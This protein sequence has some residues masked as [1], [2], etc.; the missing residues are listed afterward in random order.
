MAQKDIMP[1]NE[2]TVETDM[3]SV[4]LMRNGVHTWA[5]PLCP[6]P[7]HYRI[8]CQQKGGASHDY[9]QS[10]YISAQK[11]YQNTSP[12]NNHDNGRKNNHPC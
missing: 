10:N 7:E 5:L 6:P 9:S 3:K 8:E 2:G 12:W 4:K 11:G 1:K